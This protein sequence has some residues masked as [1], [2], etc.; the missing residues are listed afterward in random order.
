MLEYVCVRDSKTTWGGSS[1]AGAW[2]P[3]DINE[4]HADPAG[5]YSIASNQITLAAGIYRCNI[6]APFFHSS[7]ARIRLYNVTLSTTILYGTNS[8]CAQANHCTERSSIHGRF[9]LSTSTV[10]EVQYRT[11]GSYATNGLGFIDSG[12]DIYT[13]GEFWRG[14]T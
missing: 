9:Q 14:G 11:S 4:I 2:R 1:V 13:V 12:P 5:I 6:S 7:I 10:L 8:Y 3:R